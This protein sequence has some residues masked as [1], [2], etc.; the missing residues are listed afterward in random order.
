[1]VKM[2]NAM[3]LPLQGWSILDSNLGVGLRAPE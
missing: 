2:E 1:M 3:H